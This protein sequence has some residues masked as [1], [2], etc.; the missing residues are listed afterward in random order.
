[1]APKQT[2]KPKIAPAIIS[3]GLCA[4]KYNLAHIITPINSTEARSGKSKLLLPTNL[5]ERT[6]Q[7]PTKPAIPAL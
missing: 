1:M 2:T 5:A 7:K 6:I 3:D 4:F